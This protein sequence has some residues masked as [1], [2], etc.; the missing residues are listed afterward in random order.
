MKGLPTRRARAPGRPK[1]AAPKCAWMTSIPWPPIRRARRPGS[2]PGSA[3]SSTHPA[4]ERRWAS[5]GTWMNVA[6]GGG[7][8]AVSRRQTTVELTS[9]GGGDRIELAS[10]FCVSGNQLIEDVRRHAS[11]AGLRASR[12]A[13]P[14]QLPEHGAVEHQGHDQVDGRLPPRRGAAGT[15]AASRPADRARRDAVPR[16]PKRTSPLHRSRAERSRAAWS[17]PHKTDHPVRH[18][19]G[20]VGEHR[21]SRRGRRPPR[22]R[23]P[24]ATRSRSRRSSMTA[25]ATPD[26]NIVPERPTAWY[27][28]PTVDVMT[29]TRPYRREDGK[30]LSGLCPQLG[31]NSSGNQPV[32]RRHDP[33]D[34]RE[35]DEGDHRDS[36][37]IEVGEGVRRSACN[38]GVDGKRRARDPPALR[39]AADRASLGRPMCTGREVRAQVYAPIR[40]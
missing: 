3:R 20:G 34:H 5:D 36:P 32:T 11:G 24:S 19:E 26:A 9:G 14:H 40:T 22:R 38:R 1:P 15:S 25:L 28:G 33:E 27:S 21:R 39:T 37:Q 8:P 29:W 35:G 23:C 12:R 10:Q 2:S 13:A 18:G 4:N 7:A 16:R 30:H 6:E 17:A 31:T